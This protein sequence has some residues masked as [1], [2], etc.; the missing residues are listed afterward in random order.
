MLLVESLFKC[1][2]SLCILSKSVQFFIFL[3]FL[4]THDKIISI[5]KKPKAYWSHLVQTADLCTVLQ[6]AL[7]QNKVSLPGLF[8]WIPTATTTL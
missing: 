5:Q 4:V 2:S 8:P 3:Q 7:A 1:L 6:T